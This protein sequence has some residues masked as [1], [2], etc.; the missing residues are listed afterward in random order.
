MSG[1]DKSRL[2]RKLVN[3]GWRVTV[4]DKLIPPPSLFKDAPHS[5]PL[6]EAETLQDI[7]GEIVTDD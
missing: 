7:L 2:E 4:T 3:L 1:F 6:W 5:L